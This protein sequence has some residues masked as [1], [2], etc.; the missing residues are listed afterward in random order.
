MS[1]AEVYDL[2]TKILERLSLI[3][4]KINL[5]VTLVNTVN[6]LL[7]DVAGVL[8]WLLKLV[9]IKRLKTEQLLGNLNS[10]NKQ[11]VFWGA[12]F[13]WRKFSWGPMF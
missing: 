6:M 2:L 4:S 5:F 9:T 8:D 12:F 7:K 13:R 1:L 3:N 11:T 10:N